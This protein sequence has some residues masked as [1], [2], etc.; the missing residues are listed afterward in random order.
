MT[1]SG[2]KVGFLHDHDQAV[3]NNAMIIGVTETWLSDAILDAE[4]S[5]VIS[6][7][8]VLRC[9]R[10]G[11]RQGG[12]VALYLREDLTG[13]ILTTYAKVH[14]L[15]G[16]SV[17]EIIVVKIHQLDTVV[18]LVYSPPDTRMDKFAG[19]LNCL[20]GALSDLP[21]PLPITNNPGYG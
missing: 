3:R 4:V 21:S 10:A 9:D 2:H 18:C 5:H 16:G 11:G 1:Q 19:L 7:Y 15:R 20:D 6:C 12:G 17:C 8:T 14:P 13:E